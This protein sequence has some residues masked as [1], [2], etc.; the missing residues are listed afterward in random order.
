MMKKVCFM[1]CGQD[2]RSVT[3]NLE[4]GKG[5]AKI[6]RVRLEQLTPIYKDRYV[7][8]QS[9]AE[10]ACLVVLNA[11]TNSKDTIKYPITKI[12]DL[13][14]PVPVI[15][16]S[17]K[18]VEKVVELFYQDDAEK[19]YVYMEEQDFP[20]VIYDKFNWGEWTW[21]W[22]IAYNYKL[23]GRYISYEDFVKRYINKK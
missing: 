20:V 8:V 19:P 22:E 23:H 11:E 16:F 15:C 2:L 14:D 18:Q 10:G 6:E 1:D 12:I 7:L 9:V 21:D 3:I 5:I 4:K 17:L 13:P